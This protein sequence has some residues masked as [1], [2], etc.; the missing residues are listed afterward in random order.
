MTDEETPASRVSQWAVRIA[1]LALLI[2]LYW[3]IYRQ[4]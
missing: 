3:Q 4:F 1:A 2:V